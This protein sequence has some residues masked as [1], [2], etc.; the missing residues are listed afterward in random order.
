[1]AAEPF[2][3]DSARAAPSEALLKQ[4]SDAIARND[5]AAA[6]EFLAEFAANS[7]QTMEMLHLQAIAAR[8]QGDTDAARRSL[9]A[10]LKLK[11][12]HPRTLSLLARLAVERLL[13][14]EAAQ[15]LERLVKLKPD[16]HPLLAGWAEM[17]AGSGQRAAAIGALNRAIVVA[18]EQIGYRL[19]RAANL[20]ATGDLAA[21][22]ADYES[23]LAR[24]A[25]QVAA[26]VG[27][28]DIALEIEDTAAAEQ[29]LA[30]ALSV[31]PTDGAALGTLGLLRAQ[32]GSRAEALRLCQ[33]A[34][35]QR[36]DDFLAH[37]NFGLMLL[38]AGRLR[39]AWP[40]LVWRW[41]NPETPQPEK[42][43]RWPRW[44]G[45]SIDAGRVLLWPEQG[46]GD[47]L[48]FASLLPEFLSRFSAPALLA[49]ARL[50]PLL[51]RSF[52]SVEIQPDTS[53]PEALP[54]DITHQLPVADIL[55][56][57]RPETPEPAPPAGYLK[58]DPA[59]VAV[60]RERYARFVSERVIGISWRSGNP[61]IGGVKS[62]RL[63]E[64]LPILRLPGIRFVNLQYGD[65]REEL[66]AA[67]REFGVNIHTDEDVNPLRDLEGQAAQV[68]AL[69]E[70]VSVSTAV[71]HLACG[72][73]V[74]SRVILPFERGLLW[75]WGESGDVSPWRTGAKLYR[76][77]YS[78]D[79][80]TAIRRCA[81]DLAG[82]K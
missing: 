39:E 4:A 49:D 26:H 20:R 55:P 15:W 6:L 33:E 25:E 66:E 45:Q 27:L 7:V 63:E 54:A 36:P 9:I 68:A 8:L 80:I 22:R 11:P 78:G 38:R 24:N 13:P 51:R 10:A 79:R 3:H 50:V 31:A 70:V 69:H 18:P 35:R 43:A 1:V 52:P 14:G 62:L 19:Q 40:L 16:D 46:I 65:A 44:D 32:Q 29:H 21:A 75:Y 30:S 12:D 60:F 2:D 81:A 37:H 71:V 42:Y 77:E 57:L 28:A 56:L 47:Q 53:F 23:V 48:V 58:A 34:L 72:L 67:A 17:L 82:R 61:R 59:R 76:P 5:G 73:G 41:R 74:P 64:F